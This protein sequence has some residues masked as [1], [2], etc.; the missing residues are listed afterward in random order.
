MLDLHRLLL[1]G[2]EVFGTHRQDAV[3]VNVKLHLDLGRTT[4]GRWD[5]IQI[6]LAEEPIVLGHRSLTLKHTHR[7]RCLSIGCCAKD[8]LAFGRNGG[9]A[10]HEFG[11]QAPFCFDSKR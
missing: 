3:G 1:V 8:L 4:R 2:A 5:A 6:E 11:E 10:F 7:H 9:V